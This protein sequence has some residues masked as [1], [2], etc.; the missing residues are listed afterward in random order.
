MHPLSSVCREFNLS[1]QFYGVADAPDSIVTFG[2][3]SAAAAAAAA[4]PDGTSPKF[5]AYW[6]KGGKVVGAFL[7]GAS[8]DESAALKKIV[9]ADLAAPD[10]SVLKTEGAGWAV[11]ASSKL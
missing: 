4:A 2:D 10:A 8:A 5:G 7:E 6:V 11:A 9:R 1:W 3:M